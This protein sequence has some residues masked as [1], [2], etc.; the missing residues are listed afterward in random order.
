M[1]GQ[2]A[3]TLERLEKE[4]RFAVIGTAA[5][6]VLVWLISL[7]F[8]GFGIAVPLGLLIG[9][10]GMLCNLLLLRRTIQNAVYHGKT[11]DFG[12]YL[13]RCLIASAVIA[14]GMCVPQINGFCA[15]LP[16]LYPKILF[17]LLTMRKQGK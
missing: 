14:A 1:I 11:R 10:A 15:I 7:L 6:D 17:G 12:G 8:T 4:L 2:G 16:F 9:S 5:L 13:L 3:C